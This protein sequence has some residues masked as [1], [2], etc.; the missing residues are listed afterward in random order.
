MP[1]P[2]KVEEISPAT[3]GEDKIALSLDPT[4]LAPRALSPVLINVDYSACDPDGIILPL[5]L[6]IQA[7]S[8][9]NV[10]RRRFTRV[11]PTSISFIPKEAGLHG[12]LLREVGHNRW[13]GKLRIP[14]AGDL[15]PQ[16]Q[17][18]A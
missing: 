7:P 3:M 18:T 16:P 1:F 10:Q 6:I 17:R 14:V 15:V 13:V 5:E 2:A 4:T 9:A 11:A 8:A 12:V